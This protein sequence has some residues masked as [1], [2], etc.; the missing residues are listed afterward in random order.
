M[1][2]NDGLKPYTVKHT[3]YKLQELAVHVDLFNPEAGKNYV[4][5]ATSEKIKQPFSA[6]KKNF[7]MQ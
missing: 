2:T 1:L 4:A 3:K 6:S 7:F 5:T